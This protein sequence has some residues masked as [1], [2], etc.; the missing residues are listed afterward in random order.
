MPGDPG[1]EDEH[2]LR[3]EALTELTGV[4]ATQ[5]QGWRGS[6]CPREGFDAEMLS[7]THSPYLI[8]QEPG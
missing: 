1:G 2:R 6:T 4:P 5:T 7:N 3:H 8:H